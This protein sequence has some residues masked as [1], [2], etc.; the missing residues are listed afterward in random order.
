[1]SKSKQASE[2]A[3]SAPEPKAA[4]D[5]LVT[6]A[7]ER[8][9]EAVKDRGLQGYTEVAAGDVV[10]VGGQVADD[11]ITDPIKALVAGAKAHRADLKVHQKTEH[12]AHLL[13]VTKG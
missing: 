12:L 10:L 11:K 1:M 3:E 7:R 8:L 13:E 2:D 5:P 6:A 4:P 9:T